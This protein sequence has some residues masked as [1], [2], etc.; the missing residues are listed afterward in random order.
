MAVSPPYEATDE[1]IAE[2]RR[3]VSG[4]VRFDAFTRTLYSTDASIYQ[5]QPLGV[6][7][8]RTVEDVIATIEVA[9]R[10]R[11]PVL[12]RGSGSSLAGQTVGTAVV[13]DFTRHLDQ[14]V[15]V[16]A[17]EQWVRVQP[18][19]VMDTLNAHLAPL[20]LMFGP[21]PASGERASLGGIVGNNSAGSHSILYGMAV[22]N[23]RAMDCVLADGSTAHFGPVATGDLAAKQKLGGLEGDIYRGVSELVARH[24][25]E[26]KTHFPKVWRRVSGYN[27]D[28]FVGEE[29]FN[30]AGLVTG[31]EGTLA[32]MTEIEFKLVP[33]PTRT[34]LLA[35]H[36]DRMID[37]LAATPRILGTNPSAYELMDGLLISLTRKVPAYARQ[38]EHFVQGEP[39]AVFMVEYYGESEAELNA[40]LD[41]L[42]AIL[43]Q[44][45]IGGVTVRATDPAE[46]ERIWY[47]RKVGLGLLMSIKGDHKPIPFIEDAAVPIEHLATYI[48]QIQDL[49]AE[50]DTRV[51]YYAHAS[52]GVIHVRP[53]IDLKTEQGV[54]RMRAIADGAFDLVEGYGGANSGEHGDGLARSEF[55]ERIFGPELYHAFRKLK[56]IFDP[57]GIMNPGKIVD[58]GP[59]TENLRFGPAYKVRFPDVVYDYSADMG[60]DRAIEMCN[61]AG[62]CRKLDSGTM[63]PSFQA[64]REEEH[65]T[66]GR[67]NLLRAGISGLLPPEVYTSERMFEALDLCLECKSCKA[68]CPSGVDMAKLKAEWLGH[69]FAVH[70]VPLRSRLFANIHT[71]SKWGSAFAPLSNWALQSGPVRW[72]MQVTLGIHHKR[73]MPSFARVPFDRWFK[74]RQAPANKGERGQV[75]LFHD[76]F[77]TYNEPEI[78]IAATELL[79]A[80]GYEVVIV[81]KRECCGRPMISKGLLKQAKANA[82]RNVELLAPYAERGV[83]IVGC[84]PSCILTIRD[85]Y[86]ELVP[87]EAAR[88]VAGATVTLEEFV[89]QEIEAGTLA[90]NDEARK[91]LL[92]GHCYQKALVGT[93]AAQAALGGPANYTVEEIPSGCCGMAGSFGYEH[94]HFELSQQIGELVLLPAVRE[95]GEDVEIVAAGTSCRHQIALGTGREARHPALVLRE[96]L[97]TNGR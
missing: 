96:A 31:S 12:P 4:D 48:G 95:A 53:L 80:A 38:L 24:E 92:H 23:V 55:N 62:V 47:V 13:V 22:D 8:P 45:G 54:S 69:Y 61:G 43:K 35:I 37:G 9:A 68:E 44:E 64:T 50:H 57:Q 63:C 32:A 88:A 16:N 51:G 93:E 10:H 73:V 14:I 40:K 67:A 36:F 2:L 60:F 49:A 75:V 71:L 70:G 42:E 19:V 7:I 87:G 81:E 18:G 5:I 84:E 83:P 79:E 59:M 33:R 39:D 20:G 27:L 34:G 82:E 28:R 78:G 52:A 1:L 21:D 11:V 30:L 94:E 85:D 89:A 74:Q 76:T 90:F 15:E 72:L 66:R 86:P 56:G 65:S 6:V 58:A 97:R 46:I 26:I 29:S 17:E 91:V 77:L 41:A 25:N 3:H